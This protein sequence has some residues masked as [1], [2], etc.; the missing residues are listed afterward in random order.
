MKSRQ[1]EKIIASLIKNSKSTLI[2][3]LGEHYFSSECKGFSY[4][5]RYP[6]SR[7]TE[8][9]RLLTLLSQVRLC[10]VYSLDQTE[11]MMLLSQLPSFPV[12]LHAYLLPQGTVYISAASYEREASQNFC[13]IYPTI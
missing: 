2:A 13:E 10:R 9:G 4:F 3:H 5:R 12:D 7:E 8:K 11:P 6:N 1:K